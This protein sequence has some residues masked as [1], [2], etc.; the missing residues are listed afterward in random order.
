MNDTDKLGMRHLT[1]NPETIEILEE[2]LLEKVDVEEAKP[3]V[4]EHVVEYLHGLLL[5]VLS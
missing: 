3:I 4:L 1:F 5:G 2:S